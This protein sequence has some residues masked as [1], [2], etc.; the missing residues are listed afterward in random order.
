MDRERLPIS[1]AEIPLLNLHVTSRL[2]YLVESD[3]VGRR[4]FSFVDSR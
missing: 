4:R 3:L 2:K 1:D